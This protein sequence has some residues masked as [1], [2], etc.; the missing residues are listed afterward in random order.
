MLP[1]FFDTDQSLCQ[2]DEWPA[3]VDDMA[4][5]YDR[6]LTAVLDQLISLREVTRRP[7]PSGPWFDAECR[8]ARLVD[9]SVSAYRRIAYRRLARA[10]SRGSST[11]QSVTIEQ[12]AAA[13]SAWYDQRLAY[14]QLRHQ[15]CTALWLE[16]IE[17]DRFLRCSQVVGVSRQTAR[18]RAY[19]SLLIS[20][21]RVAQRLRGEGPQGAGYYVR[22]VHADVLNSMRRHVT[23]ALIR[24]QHRRRHPFNSSTTG[25]EFGC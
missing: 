15:K 2:P 3:D 22:C 12:V 7:R 25:Q 8:A 24:H 17:T 9:S 21:R 20:R 19:S 1:V 10:A 18:P 16:K 11:P 13:K 6:Q 23:P 5:L 14:R 4:A